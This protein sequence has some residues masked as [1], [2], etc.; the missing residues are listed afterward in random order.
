M[1]GQAELDRLGLRATESLVTARALIT[2]SSR[3][4]RRD[5]TEHALLAI[6]DQLALANALAMIRLAREA[7]ES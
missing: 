6:A 2:P 5:P 7:G 3:D 1:I 4:V